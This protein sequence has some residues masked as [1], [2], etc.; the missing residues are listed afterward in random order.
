[1]RTLLWIFGLMAVIGGLAMISA[2]QAG[3]RTRAPGLCALPRYHYGP[4]KLSN[5]AGASSLGGTAATTASLTEVFTTNTTAT[6]QVAVSEVEG[7]IGATPQT[8]AEI[9]LFQLKVAD[10]KIR[11]CA[12]REVAV[13]LERQS[14]K[15]VLTYDGIQ[16]IKL[17]DSRL[18]AQLSMFK[19]NFF[20]VRLR[21]MGT[22]LPESATDRTRLGQTELF[23]LDADAESFERDETRHVRIEFPDAS[24]AVRKYFDHVE[25]FEFEFR[26]Q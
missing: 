16:S 17:A 22:P 6:A 12:V 15:A 19:R 7:A 10:L 2:G 9:R 13:T 20:H 25:R 26:I 14:G 23:V 11:H 1:M 24:E 8:A 3:H 18:Q 4:A 5:P 21:A